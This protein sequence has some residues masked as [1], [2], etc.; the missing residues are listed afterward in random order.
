MNGT[1]AYILVYDRALSS[2]ESRQNFNALKG[3][4]DL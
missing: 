1:V 3:R 4:F 2:D